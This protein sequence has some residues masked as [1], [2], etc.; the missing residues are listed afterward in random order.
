MIKT[1]LI[2]A[3]LLFVAI[4]LMGMRVFFTKSGK[5]PNTHVGG[6]KAMRDRGI[7]CATSQAR[8]AYRKEC[9]VL[10]ILKEK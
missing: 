10:K 1:L 9:P 5:F 3:V 7:T 2:G 4:L 6:N 8:E